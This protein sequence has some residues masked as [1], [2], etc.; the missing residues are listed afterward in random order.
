MLILFSFAQ[1]TF[2][3]AAGQGSG[4]TNC[5]TQAI[6]TQYNLSDHIAG[7]FIVLGVSCVGVL[8][9]IVLGTNKKITN[10]KRL[11]FALQIL[12]FFGIGVIAA[13]AWI[14]ILPDAFTIFTDPCLLNQGEWGVYGS[15]YVGL[16]GLTASYV[17]QG[18]EFCT[19][20]RREAKK[21]AANKKKESVRKDQQEPNASDAS[22][23]KSSTDKANKEHE[24]EERTRDLL[25]SET[26]PTHEGDSSR[27]KNDEDSHRH[28][29]HDHDQDHAHGHR[30]ERDVGTLHDVAGHS[31]SLTH[32]IADE[33]DTVKDIGTLMLELGILTHSV[34]IGLALGVAT[35]E[36]FTLLIA[37]CFHQLFEGMA[38]GTRIAELKNVKGMCKKLGLGSLYPITTPVGIVIGIAI[39]FS[40]NAESYQGLVAQGILDSLSAGILLYNA[41]VELIS[42]EMNHN[43]KFRAQKLYRKLIYF[44]AMYV[45]AAAMAVIGIWA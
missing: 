14:H 19:I 44:L 9:T 27:D 30:H 33:E 34:I 24:K 26:G 4:G 37:I 12:K 45:G 32:A 42:V 36:F 1:K 3:Q 5:S 10:N 29:D 43:R 21:R 6:V 13:T 40:Y 38:L 23:R 16:F 8:L 18:F 28:H 20:T 7:V 31:H 15:S 25:A 2:G 11:L 39:H 22:L 41:Y 17:V 35:T